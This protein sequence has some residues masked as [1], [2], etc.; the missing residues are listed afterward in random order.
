MVVASDP[1]Y[2]SQLF[3]HVE[4]GENS[5]V[6]LID[7]D[8]IVRARRAYSKLGRKNTVLF[9]KTRTSDTGVYTARDATDGTERIYG[10]S[11]VYGYPLFVSSASRWTTRSR[12]RHQRNV[13]LASGGS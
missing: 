12:R 6:E 11:L 1:Y 13:Y 9:E 4:L 5:A 10:F 3:E 8:G 2:F 7:G